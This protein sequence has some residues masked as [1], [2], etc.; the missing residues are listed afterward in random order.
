[1]WVCSKEDFRAS[2]ALSV[3]FESPRGELTVAFAAGAVGGVQVAST[4]VGERPVNDGRQSRLLS[5]RWPRTARLQSGFERSLILVLLSVVDRK[6]WET[7]R[8]CLAVGPVGRCRGES[9]PG[10]APQPG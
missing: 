8:Y 2:F 3:Q 10:R 7:R 9:C 4:G 5:R 1:M 6:T